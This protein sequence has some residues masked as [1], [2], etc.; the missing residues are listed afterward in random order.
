MSQKIKVEIEKRI[1]EKFF[2]VLASVG[3]WNEQGENVYQKNREGKMGSKFTQQE[4]NKLKYEDFVLN[5]LICDVKT[6]LEGTE[7]KFGKGG[8]HIWISNDKNER[9]IFIHF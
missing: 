3:F 6:V 5:S 8:S 4:A 1:P 7:F 9:M 2:Q